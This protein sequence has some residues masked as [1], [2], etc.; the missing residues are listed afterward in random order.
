MEFEG[1]IGGRYVDVFD[2][3]HLP[4]SNDEPINRGVKGRRIA[5]KRHRKGY[6]VLY[7]DWH[8][9]H[10]STTGPDYRGGLSA[11]EEINLWKL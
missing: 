1:D 3:S 5:R 2:V 9:G 7:F 10:I 11:N 6:N 4:S 8:T